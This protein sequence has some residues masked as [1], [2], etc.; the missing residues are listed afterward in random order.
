MPTVPLINGVAYA[1]GNV[2]FVAF[3]VP[4]I[5][6]T[7]IDYNAKQ[8]KENNYGLGVD[9]VSR[10]RGNKEYEGSIE[11]Y[12]EEW[13][14]ICAAAPTGDPLDIDPFQVQVVIGGP[15]VRP[16]KDVLNAVEFLENP[17]STSQGDTSL[18]V[19]IPIIFAGLT[20]TT[21]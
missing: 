13:L 11:L 21:V 15:K 16:A 14:Q 18:K 7:K 10:G 4:I 1:W 12:L 8:K 9:P 19:T 17:L 20:R 2:S 5:G 6:I 3:G